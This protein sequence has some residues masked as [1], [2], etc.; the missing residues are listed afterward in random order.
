MKN[1]Y[2][3]KLEIISF[4]RPAMSCLCYESR[5]AIKSLTEKG[6]VLENV[7]L[8]SIMWELKNFFWSV[9]GPECPI[10]F[11]SLVGMFGLDI[12]NPNQP[13]EW[14]LSEFTIFGYQLWFPLFRSGCEA[15]LNSLLFRHLVCNFRPWVKRRQ[16]DFASM[17]ICKCLK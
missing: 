17:K 3:G 14:S 1:F 7:F 11:F 13:I 2:L 6:L 5:L 10:S 4:W 15:E 16:S 9:L 12:T 8:I